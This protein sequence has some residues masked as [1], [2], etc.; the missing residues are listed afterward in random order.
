MD[1]RPIKGT[2][3]GVYRL[4]LS[5]ENNFSCGFNATVSQA[6]IYTIKA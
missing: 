1:T 6:E 5:R 4:G 2:A 3:V